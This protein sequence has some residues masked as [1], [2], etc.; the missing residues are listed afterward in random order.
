[1]Y[2]RACITQWLY[3]FL[4]EE[5]AP[6][7]V[8]RVHLIE[9]PIASQKLTS[10]AC[11]SQVRDPCIR[12]DD[13]DNLPSLEEEISCLERFP[14]LPSVE[15]LIHIL[16][17]CRKEKVSAYAMR[18]HTYMQQKNL[19]GHKALGN[20]L[21]SMLADCGC[22]DEARHVF[23]TLLDQNVY[24]YNALI[25]GYIEC[26][27]PQ[28][29]FHLYRKMQANGVQ[30]TT[31]TFVAL[32]KACSLLKDLDRGRQLRDE[33]VNRGLQ[34]DI[35]VGNALVD[36]FGKCG[37][38]REAEEVFD[39]LLVRDVVSW[40]SMMAGYANHGDHENVLNCFAQMQS[41]GVLPNVVSYICGMKSCGSLK[42]IESGRQIYCDT[43][44]KGFEGDVFLGNTCIDM[45]CKCDCLVE[46][47]SIF[48]KLPNRD[49]VS[50]NALMA[51]YV[52]HG[53]GKQAL[54]LF[55]QMEL[56]HLPPDDVAFICG[57][58]A[59]ASTGASKTG[60]R[61]HTDIVNRG[62][63]GDLY[64][65]NTLV[66]MLG[67]CGLLEEAH[68]VFE[69]LPDWDAV[70]WS[71]LIL[72]YAQHGFD[73]KALHFFEK[74]QS[75]GLSPDAVVFA[76]SLKACCNTGAVDKAQEI[77]AEMVIQ[78]FETDAFVCSALVDIYAKCNLLLEARDVFDTLPNHDAVAWTALIAGYV[79]G[80]LAEDALICLEQMQLE[81]IS[82]DAVSY[83]F[84]LKACGMIG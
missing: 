4:R 79:E 77:H 12:G 2:P 18:L 44:K 38:V 56:R 60:Q 37:S 24:S 51:G 8:L 80:G 16:Q 73:D 34:R 36:V 57:L 13:C 48:D 69:E 55:R 22:V 9:G 46:A 63:E 61:L 35:F 17:R 72:G 50:W 82:P 54:V 32:L 15:T 40:S 19:Q 71:A 49:L 75:E 3:R 83:G 45:F 81:G 29:V 76:C 30:P 21:V 64:L 53:L 10:Q 41:H 1:M 20:Y 25:L 68:F 62:M 78:R 84:F 65:R 58:K 14:R 33:I 39:K 11:S 43:V 47:Q 5:S 74:M 42:A 67:K 7:R 31:Y 28:H 23:D 59:C 6:G 66:D 26:G 27:N 70:G 52:E